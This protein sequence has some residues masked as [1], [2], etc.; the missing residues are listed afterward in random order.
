MDIRKAVLKEHS[1]TQMLKVI[2]YV[3][4][5]P[6]R[7][8]ELIHIYFEGPYR[9]TQRA[10]WPLSYCIE[11]HP[12]LIKPH[13]KKALAF[14]EKPGIHDAVKRNTMRFLQ[15]VDLPKKYHGHV[16]RLCF[17]FLQSKKE[18]VAIKVFSMTVLSRIIKDEPDLKKE[19]KIILEDQQPYASPGFLSR[20]KKVL[21][22]LEK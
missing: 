3:G 5:S 8:K 4:S 6:L 12:D 19:L 18:A 13:L 14:L 11:R 17:D 2:H 16:A 15:F 10:A 9:V 20:S 7:F 22:E 1:R 21:R